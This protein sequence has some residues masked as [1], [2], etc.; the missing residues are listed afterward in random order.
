VRLAGQARDALALASPAHLRA[1]TSASLRARRGQRRYRLL[2]VEELRATR[3]SDTAFVFGSGRSLADVTSEEWERIARCNTVSLREFPRQGWV[4]ADYHLTAEV[5]FLEP[6]AERI[7]ANPLYADTVFVVQGGWRAVMGNELIAQGLLPEGA[8]V[9]RYRRRARSRYE[10]PSASFAR[11]LVHGFNS[12]TDS[13]NFALLL[14]FRR[15]VL[16]GVDMYNKEY[17]WLPAGETRAYEKPGITA[18][19]L[20]T[21]AQPTIDLLG[22]WASVAAGR[23]VELSVY[24]PKSLLAGPLPVFSWD[25]S[26]S[27][28]A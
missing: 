24:N 9:F 15:V 26:P 23:E 16:A 11:G 18:E 6:Y 17:F 28:G 12:I 7:R 1:A 5:D 14:G 8:R 4:R 22:R 27:P 19:T 25:A 10:P 3:T 13:V 20:F 2:D 21:S